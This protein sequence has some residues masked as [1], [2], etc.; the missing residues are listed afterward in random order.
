MRILFVCLG[1][2]CRSPLGEGIMRHLVQQAGL[3][4]RIEVDSAGSGAWHAGEPPDPRS[5]A[6]ARQHG[7]SL[8]GQKARQVCDADYEAFDLILAMDSSNLS[9]LQRRAPRGFTSARLERLLDPPRGD[10]GDVPDPYYGGDGGFAHVYGLV[11]KACE[12]LLEDLG[13][14]ST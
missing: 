2:I 4:H 12:Q 10:G 1:N 11:L 3:D 7:V 5:S 14:D 8:H 13:E 9:T 6:I